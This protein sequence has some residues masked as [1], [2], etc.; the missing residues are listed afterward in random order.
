MVTIGRHFS[1]RLQPPR[2][3]RPRRKSR[4]HCIC[5]YRGAAENARPDNVAPDQTEV[6]NFDSC[7]RIVEPTPSYASVRVN[8]LKSRHWR[9]RHRT[10]RCE[11]RHQLLYFLEHFYTQFGRF[12]RH[13][14]VTH[15]KREISEEDKQ[16][17]QLIINRRHHFERC[18]KV[19]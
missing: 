13:H 18:L 7:L 17:K 14:R 19:Q 2:L 10:R 15:W 12:P 6:D 11:L 3:L 8:V 1:Y 5:R 9:P 16:S 4:R